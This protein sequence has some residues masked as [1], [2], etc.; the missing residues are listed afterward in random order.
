MMIVS[1]LCCLIF[2]YKIFNNKAG[3]KQNVM[4]KSKYKNKIYRTA[5][6]EEK[7]ENIYNRRK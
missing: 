5:K 3:M 4:H 2:A 1:E 7:E 6:K